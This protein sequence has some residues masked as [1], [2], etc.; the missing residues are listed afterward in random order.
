M[1]SVESEKSSGFGFD[2]VASLQRLDEEV[3]FEL[4]EVDAVGGQL[5]GAGARAL[6]GAFGS[7][8]TG[9]VGEVF[10]GDVLAAA[11]DHGAFDDVFE[12]SDV[13]GPMVAV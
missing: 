12:F 2:A 7:C 1:I 6:L 3:S 9:E 13:S 5:V 4:F 8:L 10:F 11:E